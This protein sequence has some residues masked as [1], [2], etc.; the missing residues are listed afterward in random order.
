MLE[1][2]PPFPE[3]ESSLLAKL[4]KTAPKAA[5]IHEKALPPMDNVQEAPTTS[6]AQEPLPAIINEVNYVVYH[7]CT[8]LVTHM[9][10]YVCVLYAIRRLLI[11]GMMD[12][13]INVCMYVSA[14][15]I[16]TVL[17]LQPPKGISPIFNQGACVY[18]CLSAWMHVCLHIRVRMCCP[19]C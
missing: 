1:E 13:C 6:P 17:H 18:V 12:I 9:L 10:L 5:K 15:F 3:R 7:I 14:N 4:R 11:N 19:H 16:C 2:M 8:C